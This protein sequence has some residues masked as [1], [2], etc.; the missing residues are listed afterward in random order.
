MLLK[1]SLS[2]SDWLNETNPLNEEAN[3]LNEK[4]TLENV[5]TKSNTLGTQP[6]HP[7][8]PL[9]LLA[10]STTKPLCLVT[11]SRSVRHAH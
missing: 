7:A 1:S 6:A 10:L 8:K 11:N 2:E 9:S 5:K 4:K 3:S